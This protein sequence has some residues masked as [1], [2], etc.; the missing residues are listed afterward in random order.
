MLRDEK[1][2]VTGPAG[3]IAFPLASWLAADNEVWGLA[4]FSDPASREQVEAAGIRAVTGDLASGDLGDLPLELDLA[5]YQGS[6]LDYDHAMRVNAEATGL[7][8]AHCRTARAALVMSTHSVYRPVEDPLHV[9][10]ETDPLGDVHATH[11]PT[12]IVTKIAQEGVARFCARAFDLPVTIARMNASYGPGGGLLA[13]HADA[14]AAG[15][16]LSA[17]WD[18]CP[19][20]PIHQDDIRDQVEALLDA[21]SV[22]ALI[23]NW[24]GD[25][26]VTVQEWGA[27]LG[28]L[29][30]RPVQVATRPIEGTLRGSIADVRRRASITGPCRVGWRDGLR[31]TWEARR[32]LVP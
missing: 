17:R 9:F 5:A 18:P 6:D 27:E 3:Q 2:L 22:P 11:C 29:A 24:A 31:E 32:L 4:R 15:Q 26:P 19:Y 14:V 10:A 1:I 12:Y 20:S 23:V 13:L 30:G 7:V 21:A 28:R 25:E 16:D 8:L